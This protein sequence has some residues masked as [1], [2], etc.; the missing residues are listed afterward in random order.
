MR[1]R[2]AVPDELDDQDRKAALDAALESV[3]RTV[4]GLVRSG[5]APPAARMIKDKRVRWQPEPPGDEH[6][7]LPQTIIG[8]GHGDCD[9]LAPWHAGSLRASG[10]DPKARAFVKKSGPRRW[11]ALVRRGD[12]TIEDPSLHAGMGH[13]VSGPGQVLGSAGSIG[14]PMSA[15]G[16]M[17]LAISPSRDPRHPHIWFARCDVPDKLEPWD[18]SSVT[19]SANPAKAVLRAANTARSV[20]GS[21]M[22]PDDEARLL[23]VGDLLRGADP[24]EVADALHEI[25]GEGFDLDGCMEDA[26]H[27]VGFFGDLWKGIKK[28]VAKPFTSAVDFVKNPSLKGALDFGFSPFTG[29]LEMIKPV[30]KT[31]GLREVANMAVPLAAGAF[32]GPAGAMAGNMFN[33]YMNAQAMPRPSAPGIPRAAAVPPPPGVAPHEMAQ[34][35]Q[36]F[37]RQQAAPRFMYEAGKAVRPWGQ[38]G[39]TVMKF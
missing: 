22:D 13:G 19:A 16:R 2:L 30:Y 8:R 10:I 7:D 29:Q 23:A 26:V 1:I 14:R 24:T 31:P 21:S 34:L 15:D 27:S 32:G 39:P 4:T 35:F 38:M 17:C 33:Q 37:L 11:H 25:M 6:F 9:D 20:V 5:K 3:T 36:Q 12:G 18:W 28:G